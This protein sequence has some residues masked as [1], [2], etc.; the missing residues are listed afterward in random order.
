LVVP[1]GLQGRGI[2]F[3]VH[4]IVNRS[5]FF[6]LFYIYVM[7]RI[8]LGRVS[9][10]SAYETWEH[11]PGNEG[12]T[13]YDFFEFLQ[14]S[15]PGSP[16]RIDVV[17]K[18]SFSDFPS[19]GTVQTLYVASGSSSIY[20]WEGSGYVLV[21]TGDYS[22]IK[23]KPAIN[24]V[25]L[26]SDS[27]S[28]E[29]GL[30]TS[31]GLSGVKNSLDGHL[32]N[33]NNPHGVTK[34][35]VGL[36]NVDNTSD[37]D[38]PVSTAQQTAL[39]G[40][41]AKVVGK[42]L[43]TNDFSDTY[44]SQLDKAPADTNDALGGKV[45]KVSGKGL[46]ANDF[47]DGYKGQLD[48]A[49]DDINGALSDIGT[50]V[51]NKSVVSGSLSA[52]AVETVK[53]T[54]TKGDESTLDI[55]LS[56]L[57]DILLRRSASHANGGTSLTN[58]GFGFSALSTEVDTNSVG[59]FETS[60]EAGKPVVAGLSLK[61]NVSQ[62]DSVHVLLMNDGVKK[63]AYL[64]KNKGVPS[65]RSQ[66]LSADELLNR[67]E[68]DSTINNIVASA[69]SGVLPIPVVLD[70]E[71][72]L[73]NIIGG[74]GSVQ[75]FVIEDMD[76]SSTDAVRQG[77]A[78]CGVGETSWHIL[79]DLVNALSTDSFK[80]K[81]D[82]EWVLA[83]SVQALIDGAVQGSQ[84]LTAE[85]TSA[86][87]DSQVVSGKR[88]WSMFG[89]A[90]STFKTTA[91]T[92]VGAVNELFDLV[93]A[94]QGTLSGTAGQVVTYTDTD[95]VLSGVELTKSVV[96][97]GNVDNTSDADKPVSTAQQTAIGEK[98]TK[99]AGGIP[100]SDL[101]LSTAQ[102]TALDSGIT[103]ALVAKIGSVES[104]NLSYIFNTEDDY[105]EAREDIPDGS[106]VLIMEG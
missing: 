30:A 67:G 87:T 84:I 90:L 40:K 73:P 18:D 103:E 59:G 9:G 7:A 68:I 61:H 104:G 41:V 35:Q 14:S 52:L 53:V 37:A 26:S 97:L 39:D 10:Y 12:K 46:S 4:F 47:T 88:L 66:V 49:P 44:K 81:S 75:Y 43:S 32:N 94:K 6:S 70:K 99:P 85:P 106:R 98:Y 60:T 36:G 93:A 50:A 82:G 28:T 64:L 58:G 100:T 83:E 5:L 105:L 8:S 76:V 3:R 33:G 2:L 71:S 1:A 48:K 78:W 77:R 16:G 22:N 92:V 69:I 74:S 45:D 95:G 34:S 27:T 80:Q 23:S 102:Q 24:G 51:T 62:T 15:V 101:A 13:E 38:K 19:Q 57:A 63:S 17:I 89:A 96:G 72:S 55:S 65:S 91:K 31:S 11:L 86:A 25:P 79:L 20:S 29:L 42:G 54:L 21:A 56:D